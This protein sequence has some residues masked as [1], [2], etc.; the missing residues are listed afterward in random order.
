MLVDFF[1]HKLLS[2]GQTIHDEYESI[3]IDAVDSA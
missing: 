1:L 3:A 2:I